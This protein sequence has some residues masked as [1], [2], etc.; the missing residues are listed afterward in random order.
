[1]VRTLSH[2]IIYILY[3]IITY[4]SCFFVL[5]TIWWYGCT[6]SF[7]FILLFLI[8]VLHTFTYTSFGKYMWEFLF[9]TNVTVECVGQRMYITSVSEDISSFPKGSYQYLVLYKNH[10]VVCIDAS[11]HYFTSRLEW[12]TWTIS[13]VE[14]ALLIATALFIIYEKFRSYAFLR[15][16]QMLSNHRMKF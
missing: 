4:N 1:M 11:H 15:K 10:T 13:D 12:G 16:E 5:I 2:Y 7:K 9:N 3:Y 14:M 6:T 8:I